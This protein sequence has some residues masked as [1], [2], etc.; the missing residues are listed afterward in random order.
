[1]C[2]AQIY[3]NKHKSHGIQNV[4][5]YNRTT[6]KTKKMSNTDPTKKQ[7]VN[8]NSDTVLSILTSLMR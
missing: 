4:R 6:Q 8:S 1:M 7:G 5:T 2:W 3:T